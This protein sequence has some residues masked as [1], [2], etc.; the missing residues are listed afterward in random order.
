MIITGPLSSVSGPSCAP[1]T[2]PELPVT[3][4]VGTSQPLRVAPRQDPAG[5]SS[6]P[7]LNG[8]NCSDTGSGGFSCS[9]PAAFSGPTCQQRASCLTAGCR[10][11]GTCRNESGPA[12]CQCPEGFSG[13]GG[14]GTAVARGLLDEGHLRDC[15]CLEGFSPQERLRRLRLTSSPGGK[16]DSWS[17]MGLFFRTSR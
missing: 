3:L 8:G 2:A 4:P 1:V 15:Q 13:Q 17:G 14:T 16:M 9:C 10:N 6:A 11:G 5:C 7:C 12:A